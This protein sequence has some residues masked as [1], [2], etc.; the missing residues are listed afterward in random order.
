VL[1]WLLTQLEFNVLWSLLCESDRPSIERPAR[2]A[3]ASAPVALRRVAAR[4]NRRD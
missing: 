2:R 3:T 1:S 4:H